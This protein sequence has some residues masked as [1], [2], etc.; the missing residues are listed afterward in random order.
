[1]KQKANPAR[2]K[3][4]DGKSSDSDDVGLTTCHISSECKRNSWIVDSGATSHMCSDRRLFVEMDTLE[5]TLSIILGDGH[6]LQAT[7][8]GIVMLDMKLPNGNTQKCKL[9][10]VLYV[11]HSPTI[12]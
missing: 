6:A 2:E 1:M 8:K 12:Y 3:Q 10:D 9:H 5:K 11:P 4:W 7:G